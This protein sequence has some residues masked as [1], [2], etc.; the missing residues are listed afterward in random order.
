MQCGSQERTFEGSFVG[1][2]EWIPNMETYTLKEAAAAGNLEIVKWLRHEGAPWSNKVFNVAS[3]RGYLEIMK[4]AKGN[5]CPLNEGACSAAASSGHL[6][7]L[8]WLREN[9]C[10]WDSTTCHTAAAGGHLEVLKWA[11]ENG[12]PWHKDPVIMS[13]KNRPNN[14]EMLAWLANQIN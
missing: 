5:G 10:S 14:E 8:K 1:K 13:A 6:E 12:C 11:I 2:G 4:W 7:V 3:K 9:G